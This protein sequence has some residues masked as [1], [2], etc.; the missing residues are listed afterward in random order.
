MA[1]AA[2][3]GQ[4]GPMLKEF[5]TLM[6]LLR[7]QS[8]ENGFARPNG[9]VLSHPGQGDSKMSRATRSFKL[10]LSQ[11]GIDTLIETHCHLIRTTRALI[12]WGTTLHVA[13]DHLGTI[14]AARI[15]ALLASLDVSHYSGQQEHHVG[16][17]HRLWSVATGIV[18]RLRQAAPERSPPTLGTIYI[19]ALHE[20]SRAAQPAILEA[21][22][23]SQSLDGPA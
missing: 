23:R 3:V 12:A 19:L 9:E 2:S 17:P 13:V 15:L 16:A 6:P 20:L 8:K 18:E 1:L 5:G 11:A 4:N 10:K 7:P 21:Y 14:P 22:V